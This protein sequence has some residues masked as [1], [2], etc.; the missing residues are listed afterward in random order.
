MAIYHFSAKV[1]SRANGSSAVASAAYRAAERLHDDRLGRDHDFSNKAGVVHSEIMLPDGAPER[2]NDRAT[3]WNEVEG[4]EKRKDAQ[5]AREVEFSIPRELNQQQGIQL[6]REFVEKQFVERGMVA[7]MNVHWDKAKDGTPKP[8][9]HVMLA[10]RDMGPDGFGKK[11][12]DWNST[13][14]LKGWR[15]AW[16]AHVNE[17]MAE[18]G[19]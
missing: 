16:S 17:R 19:L 8:H 9:A 14:L 13:E 11:N 2:L 5:L 15:E 6:A 3:L 10:M 12:R 4:A 7:D 1:I 18:L